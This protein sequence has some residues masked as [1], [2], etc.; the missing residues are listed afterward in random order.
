MRDNYSFSLIKVDHI[1]VDKNF[2]NFENIS[3]NIDK[4]ESNSNKSSTN[5]NLNKTSKSFKKKSNDKNND[6]DLNKSKENELDKVDKEKDNKS[7][8]KSF[9]KNNIKKAKNDIKYESYNIEI[10]EEDQEIAR[11]REEKMLEIAKKQKEMI[12]KKENEKI[13]IM[14]KNFEKEKKDV[15]GVTQTFDCKGNLINIKAANEIKVK[16]KSNDVNCNINEGEIKI[17]LFENLLN[18]NKKL[19]VKYLS[20]DEKKDKDE[21]KKNK[22]NDKDKD[23]YDKDSKITPVGSNYA[24]IVPESGVKISEGMSNKEG[25]I[26]YL[27]KYGKYSIREYNEQLQVR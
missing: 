2:A 5:K 11:I 1:S 18:N 4:E 3:E 23:K 26:D 7:L 8:K 16:L 22:Y 12:K 14:E 19:T 27:K 6:K 21:A 15:D 24:I 13:L 10:V 17:N 20:K 25:Q 9:T